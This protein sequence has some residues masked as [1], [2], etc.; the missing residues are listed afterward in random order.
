VAEA[1]A[2]TVATSTAVV[3]FRC[4]DDT[5][6]WLGNHGGILIIR[7]TSDMPWRLKKYGPD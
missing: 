4:N 5:E 1:S 3:N 6:L 2:I 7:P